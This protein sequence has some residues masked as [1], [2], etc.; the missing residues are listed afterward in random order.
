[1]YEYRACHPTRSNQHLNLNL[2]NLPEADMVLEDLFTKDEPPSGPQGFS[3]G[4][5]D[6]LPPCNQVA[7]ADRTYGGYLALRCHGS[8]QRELLCL[9]RQTGPRQRRLQLNVTDSDFS[10]FEG[11]G[12]STCHIWVCVQRVD[13]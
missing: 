10:G 2:T 3:A 8:V 5:A 11:K 6:D 12:W 13:R 9:T 4:L 7:E 1:M